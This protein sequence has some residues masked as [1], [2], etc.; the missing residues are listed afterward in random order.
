M[1]NVHVVPTPISVGNSTLE[2]QRAIE[3]AMLGSRVKTTY[4]QAQCRTAI[5]EMNRRLE[6]SRRKSLDG[7]CFEPESMGEA[8]V[9][10]WT[11]NG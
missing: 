6:E 7:G 9:Q 4:R 8:Y 11:S 5:H 3:R 10:Q 2:A 1:S